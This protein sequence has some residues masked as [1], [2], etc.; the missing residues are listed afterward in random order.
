MGEVGCGVGGPEHVDGGPVDGRQDTD[1][2]I[3]RRGIR[4]VSLAAAR[5]EKDYHHR[6]G[7]RYAPD[8]L[9]RPGDHRM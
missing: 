8:R 6:Q 9:C 7:Q 4:A 3:G 1:H 5:G 2:H